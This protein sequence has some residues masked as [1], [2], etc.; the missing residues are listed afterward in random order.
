MPSQ[1]PYTEELLL[2]QKR[3]DPDLRE[4]VFDVM[5]AVAKKAWGVRELYRAADF[6]PWLMNRHTEFTKTGMR[7]AYASHGTHS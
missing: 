1:G 3:P 5:N 2:L 4:A 7:T 6:H